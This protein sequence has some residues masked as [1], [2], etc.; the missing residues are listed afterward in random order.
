MKLKVF[1]LVFLLILTSC[2]VYAQNKIVL[3]TEDKWKL[4]AVFQPSEDGKYVILLHDL[5]RKKE[6]FSV[7]GKSL[8]KAGF[9]YLAVD[10]RGHGQ[11]TNLNIQTNFKKTGEDNEFNQ[12][13]K[14]VDAAIGYLNRKGVYNEN[15]FLLGA[16]L[17]ANI[18]AKSLPMHP[19]I[20]GVILLTPSLKSRDVLTMAGIRTFKGPVFIGVSVEDR[21]QFME[22]SFI[23]NAA[24]L[25]SGQGKVTFVTS[26]NLKGVEMLNRFITD[27]LLQWL[28]TPQLPEVL[29]DNQSLYGADT[30]GIPR[31]DMQ[32]VLKSLD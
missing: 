13:T 21:K 20:G 1:A 10:L 28:K 32:D 12:M 9:G 14:D 6:D 11:S 18:A 5:G 22:A 2:A 15:I 26:Y 30:Q 31:M 16:G 19:K 29:P 8:E 24:F 17:G 7:F 23:R 3:Q 27:E 25:A 4:E